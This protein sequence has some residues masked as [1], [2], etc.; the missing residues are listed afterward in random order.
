MIVIII[1]INAIINEQVSVPL[2]LSTCIWEVSTSVLGWDTG[3][4]DR[5][6]SWFSSASP[7][8]FRVYLKWGP[9]H[10]LPHTLQ[11]LMHYSTRHPTLYSLSNW[12]GRK[13][14][15]YDFW[16]KATHCRLLLLLIQHT[17]RAFRPGLWVARGGSMTRSSGSVVVAQDVWGERRYI[18]TILDLGTRWR[19]AVSFTPRPLYSRRKSPG[20][21]LYRRLGWAPGPVWTLRRRENL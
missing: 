3:Y 2:E 1:I 21:P 16:L 5:S 6:F 18:S 13:V 15:K 10:F 20:Y 17:D 11:S 14:N 4:P 19:W 7:G 12:Q 8:K 9:E